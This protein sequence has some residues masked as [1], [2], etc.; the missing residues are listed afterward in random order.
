MQSPGATAQ[1]SVNGQNVGES[2]TT[3]S[4]GKATVGFDLPEGL[5]DSLLY[6]DRV[7][8]DATATT[9]G[10]TLSS[11]ADCTYR[12]QAQIWSFKVTNEGRTQEPHRRRQGK[13][14]MPDRPSPA[15][16][17]VVRL[18]D[19]RRHREESGASEI[20]AGDTLWMYA[21]MQDGR[22]VAIPLTKKSSERAGY[23]RFVGEYVDETY[24]QLLADNPDSR[25]FG[26]S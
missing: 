9:E 7:K 23:V 22:T 16:P 18:L 11:Y 17:E 8:V 6:G 21:V 12:P 3:N 2:V 15:C 20:N 13:R 4:K 24:L 1:L 25:S 26:I 19:V 14:Q 5:A 10:A